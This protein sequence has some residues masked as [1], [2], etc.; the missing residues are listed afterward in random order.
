MIIDLTK[1]TFAKETAQGLVAVDFWATWCG[2]C[3][4]MAPVLEEADQNIA[5][6]KICK[7]N[8]DDQGDL[9]AQ[10]RIQAIP[11]L[12]IMKD[13]KVVRTEVGYHDYEALEAIIDAARKA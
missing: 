8:V 6:L 10:F 3:R 13:G 11:T 5:D 2:P 1:E 9:A 7:V 4:M 12:V